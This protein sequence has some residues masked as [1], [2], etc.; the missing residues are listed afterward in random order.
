M[1]NSKTI[2]IPE[3]ETI[4]IIAIGEGKVFKTTKTLKQALKMNKKPGFKY[5]YY[6]VGFSQFKNAIEI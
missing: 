1:K 2:E 5:I 4:E 6:Q 3:T